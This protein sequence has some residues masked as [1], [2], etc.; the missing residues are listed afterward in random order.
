MNALTSMNG[1]AVAEGARPVLPADPS[2][3]DLARLAAYVQRLE[4]DLGAAREQ[5]ANTE[6]EV[7]ELQVR[8]ERGRLAA[9]EPGPFMPE[10]AGPGEWVDGWLLRTVERPGARWCPQWREHPE[11][12]LHID[13]L[14]ADWCEC[15]GN[16]ALGIG[17]FLRKSLDYSLAVLTSA[18]GPFA[19]CRPGRHEPATFLG[20]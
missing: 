16:R 19:S 20:A 7:D 1:A 6:A 8:L 9:V 5:L 18:S 13:L 14:F 2:A 4:D 12:A 17:T 11:A 15:R 3:V 10:F